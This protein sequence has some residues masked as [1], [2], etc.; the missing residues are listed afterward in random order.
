MTPSTALFVRRALSL[1]LS[2]FAIAACTEPSRKSVAS[3]AL[4]PVLEAR[5]DLSDSAPRAQSEINV[6]VQLRGEQSANVASFTARLPYDSVG[7][8][9]VG[10][11]TANDGATRIVNPQPGL[12]R[13]AGIAPQG[14]KDGQLYVV[15]FSVV[16]PQSLS[17]LRLL[18]DELHTAARVDLSGEVAP[19]NP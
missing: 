13:I 3:A 6:T 10:E 2:V 12:L 19:R 14:F 1:T 18:M 16:R 5:L 15:R 7:L 8:R 17:S 11:V 9:Y 4:S